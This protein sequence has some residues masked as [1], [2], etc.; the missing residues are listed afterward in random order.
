MASDS[1]SSGNSG[2]ALFPAVFIFIVVA[3]V[4][5]DGIVSTVV[6]LSRPIIQTAVT[7]LHWIIPN[8]ALQE[9]RNILPSIYRYNPQSHDYSTA[10]TLMRL[11][12]YVFV[13]ILPP[14]VW[15]ILKT[16]KRKQTIRK[17]RRILSRDNLL[18]ILARTNP[19]LWAVVDQ[20]ILER[21]TN[22]GPWAVSQR[23]I[24]FARNNR[25]L[26]SARSEILKPLDH[27]IWTKP[28]SEIRSHFPASNY[29][30]LSR[31][32]TDTLYKKLLGGLAR[33]TSE[34]RRDDPHRYLIFAGLL[35][36]LEGSK[37]HRNRGF[38]F[39]HAVSKSLK[40]HPEYSDDRGKALELLSTNLPFADQL[41]KDYLRKDT[42]CKKLMRKI[43]GQ[44][45]YELTLFAR[46]FFEAKRNGKTVTDDFL[47]LKPVDR[48]LFYTLCQIGAPTSYNENICDQTHFCETSA[49]AAHYMAEK[50]SES[51]ITI[52]SIDSAS[53]A[54]LT[55]LIKEKWVWG[56]LEEAP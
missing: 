11:N 33:K 19:S 49:V 35:P 37:R 53:D 2:G 31:A 7:Y 44:H 30:Y 9:M 1:R 4:M 38:D 17:Y 40:G 54:L 50:M 28:I 48:Q 51:K 52:P 42:A 34:M 8:G 29:L 45:A 32:K 26:I 41:I 43:T 12:A 20:N 55:D 24:E 46:M 3:L 22:A 16:F 27:S 14:L 39:F 18:R 36:F 6:E 25:L 13:W 47:W 5:K 56:Y 10:S 21:E 23:S 15:L